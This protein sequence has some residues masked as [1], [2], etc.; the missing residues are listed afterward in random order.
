MSLPIRAAMPP[1]DGEGKDCSPGCLTTFTADDGA[2]LRVRV[3]GRGRPLV[4]LHEWAADHSVWGPLIE[5]LTRDHSVYA[6]DAR[7]HGE[8]QAQ[9]ATI[10]RMG[11]DLAALIRHFGLDAPLLVGHSLGALTIWQYVRQFGCDGIGGVCIIDQSPRLLTDDDWPLGIYGNFPPTRNQELLEALTTDFP[12]AVL[13][14]VANGLNEKGRHLVASNSRGIQRLRQRLAEL[15]PKPLIA[16]WVSLAEADF[17]PV[18]PAITVPTLLIYA[19]DSN[20]YGTAV[21]RWVHDAIPG[22][23]LRLYQGADHSPH[24]C[25]RERFLADLR[26]F[27]G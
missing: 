24:H 12:A 18:L 15:D 23:S 10:E 21:A 9:S 13:G 16:C 27:F 20:Y 14:L 25:E 3:M 8:S 5:D 19:T 11:H 6:W 1:S 7:G 26:E 2:I 4:L 22:S 17:R